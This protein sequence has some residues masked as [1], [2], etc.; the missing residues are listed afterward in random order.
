MYTVQKNDGLVH[1]HYSL[2]AGI[3]V[4]R[5]DFAGS[6]VGTVPDM[7]CRRAEMRAMDILLLEA[8]D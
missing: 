1:I 8:A 6:A 7:A 5:I 3:E 2:A 4:D